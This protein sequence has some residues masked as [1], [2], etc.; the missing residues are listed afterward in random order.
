MNDFAPP[1]GLPAPMPKMPNQR[2]S[3][4]VVEV[5][6]PDGTLHGELA[7]AYVDDGV[8]VQSG[9]FDGLTLW[10]ANLPDAATSPLVL[11]VDQFEEV[12]TACRDPSERDAFVSL[13]LHAAG[14]RARHVAVLMTLRSDF[15]G[16]T[17]R[18][19]PE[20]N[21]LVAEQAVIVPAMSRDELR[22]AIVE[23]AI[24]AGMPIDEATVE[25]LLMEARGSE[26]ALPLLEFALTRIWEGL[27]SG[28]P[29]GA[30]LRDIGG[31]GGALASTA[32]GIYS[33]LSEPEQVIARRALVRLVQLGEGTRDTRRRV[34]LGQLCGRGDRE[35]DVLA[36][37]RKYR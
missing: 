16:E 6:S 37:L 21:R 10:A 30:T 7:A 12:Y 36:V 27:L 24:Q 19:H 13:L 33:A 26:G 3:R 18:Q 35:A 2:P 29:A 17:H 22:R 34:P 11:L 8:N 25:L 20:L 5:V 32:K 23:P 31:I 1:E 14:D 4:A 28:R 15:L 9:E